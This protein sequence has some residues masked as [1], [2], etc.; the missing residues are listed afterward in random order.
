MR[1]S[2]LVM[3]AVLAIAGIS[4]AYD[5]PVITNFNINPTTNISESNPANISANVSGNNITE[6]VFAVIDTKNR[7]STNSTIL[8][9]YVNRSETN[10]IYA[11]WWKARSYS[12]TDGTKQT[13]VSR[14]I[15]TSCSICLDNTIVVGMFK[16]NNTEPEIGASIWF[17]WSTDNLTNISLLRDSTFIDISPLNI[18]YGNSTVRFGRLIVETGQHPTLEVSNDRYILYSIENEVN[19]HLIS[20]PVPQDQ[21]SVMAFALDYSNN[22]SSLAGPIIVE[23]APSNPGIDYDINSNGKIDKGEAVQAVIAYFDG[24]IT[25]QHAIEVVVNYF[26]G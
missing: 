5:Q 6:V 25:R 15:V 12:V 10:G 14:V 4:V 24:T 1:K 20:Y 22:R 2:I 17:N 8:F 16:K 7:V 18:E 11:D 26:R 13:V 19:P 21:Y 23:T 3:L 9:Y